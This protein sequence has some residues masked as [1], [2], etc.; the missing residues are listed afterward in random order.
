MRERWALHH[1]ASAAFIMRQPA[2]P[3]SARLVGRT[4]PRALPHLNL[5]AR[6]LRERLVLQRR[7]P[8]CCRCCW[9]GL[10]AALACYA[11]PRLS[12]VRHGAQR[13]VRGAAHG[14]AL[15]R[16]A[17]AAALRV[18]A[19]SACMQPPAAAPLASAVAVTVA[20]ER[21]QAGRQAGRPP[22]AR[23]HPGRQ[24]RLA[25]AQQGHHPCVCV[26]A[27]AAA[28][29]D[30]ECVRH[31]SPCRV[32]PACCI[33]TPLARPLASVLLQ[34]CP[35]PDTSQHQHTAAQLSP[36]WL[37]PRGLVP[38]CWCWWRCWLHLAA[39]QLRHPHQP[40]S[41]RAWMRSRMR[42]MRRSRLRTPPPSS[43][44]RTLQSPPPPR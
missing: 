42:R 8:C 11:A 18:G 20:V 41:W 19:G 15:V 16:G 10:L 23:T 35:Q 30:G 12:G 28:A 6:C 4:L 38:A 40:R 17:A 33:P 14:G 44:S 3:A 36:A 31:T 22:E 1:R 24:G 39:C 9:P 37:G 26:C 43:H 32:P 25:P 21:R 2:A 34:C 13:A 7:L 5:H 27:P 29:D